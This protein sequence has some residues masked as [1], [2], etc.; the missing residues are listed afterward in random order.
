[1]VDMKRCYFFL[2]FLFFSY[3]FSCSYAITPSESFEK[4]MH[5]IMQEYEAVG[6]SVVLV[7]NNKIAFSKSF[8]YNPNYS[9]LLARDSIK[10]TDISWIASV[11]KTFVATAIMQLVERGKI[12]LDDDINKY[13]DFAIRNP[14]YPSIPITIRMLLYHRSSLRGRM[15]NDSFD[16][17]LPQNKKYRSYFLESAPGKKYDYCNAGYHL[18][19]AIIEKVT[20]TRFDEYIDQNIMKP[21]NLYGGYDVTKLDSKRFVWSLAYNKKKEKYAKVLKLYSYDKNLLNNYVLGY[22]S[23]CLTPS[24][25]MKISAIDLA[26]F[27]MMHMND[28]M[29]NGKRIITKDSEVEMRNIPR[30]NNNYGLALA[31][32]SNIINNVELIGMTGGSRG[33]HS[34]M[35]FNPQEKYGFVVICNGCTSQSANGI[36]MNR[37]IVREMYN[38]FIK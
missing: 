28:G 5:K 23:P 15:H 27:M 9:N 20:G 38:M 6:V 31:R 8:G 26:K 24:G 13:L 34:A 30:Y 22:S 36:Q 7:K 4:S 33:M 18:L 17:L 2:L 19:A 12:S 32:Y 29:Y 10:S 14:Y 35:F 11:S 3:V 37:K 25:G 21:L 16:L 1:M